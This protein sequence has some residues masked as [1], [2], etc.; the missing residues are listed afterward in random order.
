M[1]NQ[2]C[3]PIKKALAT[4]YGFKN[5]TVKNGT[6]TA[7]G[8]VKIGV[9]VPKPEVADHEHSEYGCTK[10]RVSENAISKEVEDLASQALKDNNLKFHTYCSDGGYNSER[11]CVLIDVNFIKPE[12]KGIPMANMR[13]F[14][15]L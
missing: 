14:D 12:E 9:S 6:G 4:K 8:W 3:K 13:D 10:C 1:A 7:W 15:K 2:L 11:D 5:V